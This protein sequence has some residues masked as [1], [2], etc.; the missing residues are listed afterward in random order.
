MKCRFCES[1]L[2]N[3]FLDLGMSTL[4]NA[5][6]KPTELNI[7]EP[8]YPLCAYVCSNCFLVQIDE[9]VKPQELFSNYSYF[10]SFSVTWNEHIE[11]FVSCL[12]N[13]FLIDKQKHVIE[14]ASNDGYLLQYFK[15]KRIQILGIEP[16]KNI[17]NYAE[18]VCIQTINKFFADHTPQAILVLKFSA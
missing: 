11:E 12:T 13:R 4:A 3:I 6:L 5:F 8:R 10:S 7:T 1:A 2:T 17:A 18:S 16:A 14:I 9:F 15:K